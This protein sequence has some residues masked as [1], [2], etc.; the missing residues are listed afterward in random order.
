MT[1]Y[2]DHDIYILDEFVL[3][4]NVTNFTLQ[5]NSDIVE[6]TFIRCVQD[7]SVSAG[8][9]FVNVTD[10]SIRNIVINGCGFTGR[11]ISNTIG[12]LRDMVN[13][14]YV[15]PGSVH[16]ALLLGDCEN[17]LIEQVSIANT[18]GF[19][20]VAINVVGISELS[21]VNFFNNTAPGECS[22]TRNVFNPSPSE[23]SDYDSLGGG[24]VFM[25]FDYNN[26]A[27]QGMYQG[28]QFSLSLQNCNFTLNSECSLV[29][30]S[31]LRSPG[32]GE[33]KLVTN[34]GYTLGGS[35]ALTLALTQLE[36]GITVHVVSSVFHDNSATFGSGS[37]VAMFTGINKTHVVFNDCVFDTSSVTFFNDV[38]QP[39]DVTSSNPSPPFERYITF[40]LQNSNFTNAVEVYAGSPLLI[41]SN[42]YSEI[43]TNSI[44]V[45]VD[46]CIFSENRA[47]VGSAMAVYEYKINGFNGGMQIIIKDSHFV[48][49]RVITS[50]HDTMMALSQSASTVNVRNVNLTLYG[51]CSF[52]DNIGTGIKARSSVIGV[53]GNVT[54]LRNTGIN[55]GALSLV[56]HSY[57]IMNR[58]ASIY[59]I[60]NE[61]KIGGG[62]VYT[63]ENGIGSYLDWRLYGLFRTLCL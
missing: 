42:Y 47:T 57:L 52:V 33:S 35:G 6:S 46:N 17:V 38:R 1:I 53:S 59:F 43:V 60:E 40:S 51:N 9:A 54:F 58:N 30:L 11:D 16:I 23:L 39:D 48:N 63:N 28:K 45:I 22:P 49:N 8:L 31:L 55:G 34:R 61:A 26:M 5:A 4:Q 13:V 20:L 24:A 15:I 21:H 56:T 18:K 27:S 2:L 19:G 37:T 36:Y 32:S 62:A 7:P 50:D 29:Y 14:F 25:Y 41:Y 44:N 3:I 10:L 12:R